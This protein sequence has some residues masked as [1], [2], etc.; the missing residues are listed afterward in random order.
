MKKILICCSILLFSSVCLFAQISKDSLLK[1]MTKETCTQI[2]NKDFSGKNMDELQMELGLA[3]MPVVMK[4]QD[5]LQT[6]FGIS[7]E[8]QTGMEKM[9]MEIGLQLAKDCPAF[10]KMFAT[11]PDLMKDISGTPKSGVAVMSING[12]LLKIVTGDFTYIQV[13]DASGKIEKLWWMEY[14][15]GSA[16]LITDAA[17][18][19]NKQVKVNY[20][21]KEIYNATL[22]EYIKIKVIKGL[23]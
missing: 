20:T 18:M 14:F 19:V 23:E 9:G 7:M 3:M 13:K 6:A 8:D 21:E 5:E 15:D 10:L 17:T 12:T 1:L 4:Y 16:K 22:K 2:T 11:N